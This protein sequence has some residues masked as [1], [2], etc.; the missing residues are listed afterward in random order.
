MTVKLGGARCSSLF[1]LKVFLL[2]KHS[3]KHTCATQIEGCGLTPM[4]YLGTIVNALTTIVVAIIGVFSARAAQRSAK[5]K[6][7]Q[8][9]LDAKT[10]ADEE[11]RFNDLKTSVDDLVTAVKA[12]Q[13]TT[14][15][16]NDNIAK[17]HELSKVD[18]DYTRSVSN[19]ITA[20]A[21]GLRDNNIDG[22]VSKAVETF[23]QFESA[24]LK[25]LY[26]L[27]ADSDVH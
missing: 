19:V 4:E 18:L 10:K 22:N 2:P 12:L 25:T 20:L 24:Q 16:H 27:L 21:E 17:L 15:E 3:N 11:Q 7:L 14:D 1:Y 6:K 23:R 26:N 8:E 5:E 9:E 13:K